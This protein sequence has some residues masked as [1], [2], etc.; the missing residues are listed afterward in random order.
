MLL[1]IL[2]DKVVGFQR[3]RLLRARR[4]LKR[5]HIEVEDIYE[6]MGRYENR[7]D[8]D[9]ITR[10]KEMDVRMLSESLKGYGVQSPNLPLKQAD[11]AEAWADF[12]LELERILA[13]GD[14][15]RA[16]KRFPLK[17]V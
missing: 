4:S 7:I 11:N 3:K 1:V 15:R 9:R 2:A 13:D 16:K 12:L 14:I 5:L 8:L 10:E 6:S 17:R